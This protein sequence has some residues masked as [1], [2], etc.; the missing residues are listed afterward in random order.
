MR[1]KDRRVH[2]TGLNALLQSGGF[3]DCN[4]SFCRTPPVHQSS[5]VVSFAG[6]NACDVVLSAAVSATA[7]ANSSLQLQSLT[8]TP[9]KWIDH[10]LA[11]GAIFHSDA[12]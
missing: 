10:V 7:I 11:H 1:G 5:F 3:D 4:E 2:M 6:H 8:I 12:K 9:A